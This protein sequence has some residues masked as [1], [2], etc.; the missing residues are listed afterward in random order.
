MIILVF[1]LVYARIFL[2]LQNTNFI[3]NVTE[4]LNGQQV[5]ADLV[6]AVVSISQALSIPITLH[7]KPSLPEFAEFDRYEIKKLS[8]DYYLSTLGNIFT[9][10]KYQALGLPISHHAL[11]PKLVFYSFKNI[12]MHYVSPL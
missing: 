8:L 12:C 9:Y 7:R 3:I 1:S 4:G 5:N 2:Y 10:M 11:Y 6:S